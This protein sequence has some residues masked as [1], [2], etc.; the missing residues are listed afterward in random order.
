M[1]VDLTASRQATLQ[2]TVSWIRSNRIGAL[3]VA[4]PRESHVP[5]GI[6]DQ[7]RIFVEGLLMILGART[8][9]RDAN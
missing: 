3:N 7:A 9:K 8:A 1:L 5:G 4:G 6:Y 2:G